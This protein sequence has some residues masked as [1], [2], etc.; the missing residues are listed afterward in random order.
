M[1]HGYG[2]IKLKQLYSVYKILFLI[3]KKNPTTDQVLI[4]F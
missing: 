4:I 2:N 1:T 3:M